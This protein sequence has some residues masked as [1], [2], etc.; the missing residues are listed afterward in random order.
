MS[1]TIVRVR[2]VLYVILHPRR[3]LTILLAT[4]G[5]LLYVWVA[6]V[7]AVPAVRERKAAARRLRRRQRE[8][9]R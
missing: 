2:G 3:L 4:V 6:A 5:A 7:R 1:L 8:E 9:A